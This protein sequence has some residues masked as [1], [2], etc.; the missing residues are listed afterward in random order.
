MAGGLDDRVGA[1]VARPD[2]HRVADRIEGDLRFLEF[3]PMTEI[4]VR[5]S[6][7]PPAGR[8]APWITLGVASV[9][10]QT[11][12]AL[13]AGSSAT[14]GASASSRRA[15]RGTAADQLP[16]AGLLELWTRSV[17]LFSRVQTATALPAGSSGDLRLL[18]VLT[19][20]ERSTGRPRRR[21]RA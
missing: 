18:G 11:A 8:S 2:G 13:P 4:T 15:E 14:C 1:V 3:W 21:R 20:P 19:G 5:G 10:D 9:R 6:Q 16:P 17:G 7:G 12:T